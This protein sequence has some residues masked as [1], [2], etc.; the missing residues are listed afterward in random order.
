MIESTDCRA[1]PDFYAAAVIEEDGS[2]TP[3]T[4]EMIVRACRELE[5]L[6]CYAAQYHAGD[7]PR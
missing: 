7:P 5:D 4:E 2:E 1:Y 3:I 6:V